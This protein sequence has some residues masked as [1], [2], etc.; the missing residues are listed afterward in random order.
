MASDELTPQQ[1]WRF[2]LWRAVQ[3]MASAQPDGK[4][5][6]RQAELLYSLAERLRELSAAMERLAEAGEEYVELAQT[7][8]ERAARFTQPSQ[9]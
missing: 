4:L 3:Q 7:I 5:T 2:Q 8:R 6:D 1:R 9:G